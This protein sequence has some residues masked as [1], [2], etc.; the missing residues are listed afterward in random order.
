MRCT[1]TLNNS[2]LSL[3]EPPPKKKKCRKA[4]SIRFQGK[5]LPFLC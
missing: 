2:A 1:H 5:L 4:I 3:F